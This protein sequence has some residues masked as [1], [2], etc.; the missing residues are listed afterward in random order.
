MSNLGSAL[1]GLALNFDVLHEVMVFSDTQS[2][3]RLSQ[4]C[5]ILH[6][7]GATLLLKR[8]PVVINDDAEFMSLYTFLQ[9][10]RLFPNHAL[11]NLSFCIKQVPRERVNHF[12]SILENSPEL[13]TLRLAYAE[14]VLNSESPS[15]ANAIVALTALRDLSLH[16]AK[17]STRDMLLS[18]YAPLERLDISYDE[19]EAI[20]PFDQ[21]LLANQIAEYHP[22]LICGNFASTLEEL[23]SRFSNLLS[24]LPLPEAP[25]YANLHR[26]TLDDDWPFLRHWITSCPNLREL[27]CLSFHP[28]GD[29][30]PDG[31]IDDDWRATREEN[32]QDQQLHGSWTLLQEFA[33]DVITTYLVGLTCHVPKVRIEGDVRPGR[34]TV[35]LQETLEAV[36]P[37]Y[38]RVRMRGSVLR[39]L[40]P[41]DGL[42]AVL[43]AVRTSLK[44]LALT[45]CVERSPQAPTSEADPELIGYTSLTVRNVYCSRPSVSAMNLTAYYT[46][47]PAYDDAVAH[48]GAN[49]FGPST[50][51]TKRPR[52]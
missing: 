19:P 29:P 49:I 15:V 38:L 8:G 22:L 21:A 31:P 43:H 37:E 45:L 16:R 39:L 17:A 14:S 1:D 2:L 25:V 26:L 24:N 51:R 33:G 9:R 47:C 13:E 7:M 36:Q 20:D 4:T 11:R 12:V 48:P 32:V 30:T 41:E 40:D 3:V 35:M 44:R 5:K 27:F 42:C 6:R 10:H 50:R 52:R 23:S 34:F 18:L 46:E 28:D